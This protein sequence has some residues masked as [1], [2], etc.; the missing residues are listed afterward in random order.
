MGDFLVILLDIKNKDELIIGICIFV[1]YV[2][3]WIILMWYFY[4]LN[5]KCILSY[6]IELKMFLLFVEFGLDDKMYLI[7]KSGVDLDFD[8][9]LE[10][11]DKLMLFFEF[12]SVV[13]VLKDK[14]WVYVCIVISDNVVVVYKWE[15]DVWKYDWML[16]DNYDV[17]FFLKFFDDEMYLVVIIVSG[18]KLWNL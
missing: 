11:Y 12:Y 10:V 6:V 7:V 5:G 13:V 4:M 18:Y 14:M 9:V 3:I 1:I 2:V 8:M 17:I 16:G 15:M